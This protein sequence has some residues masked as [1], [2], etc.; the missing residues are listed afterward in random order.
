MQNS[1]NHDGN[2]FWRRLL[3]QSF[4]IICLTLGVIF[5][6]K[7]YKDIF[8]RLNEINETNETHLLNRVNELNNENKNLYERI[9]DCKNGT[10]D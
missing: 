5:M 2:D 1:S 6:F 10:N 9:I 8:T 3:E 7:E 4:L